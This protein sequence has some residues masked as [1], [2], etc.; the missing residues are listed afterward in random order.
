MEYI[1]L[2]NGIRM[3]QEGFSVFRSATKRSA[4]APCWMRSALAID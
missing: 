3:P 4:N 2:N 1:T